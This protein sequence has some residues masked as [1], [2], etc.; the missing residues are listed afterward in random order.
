MNPA[1]PVTATAPRPDAGGRKGPLDQ[2]LG[3]FADVKGGELS[4][5][6]V[7]KK[8]VHG[9]VDRRIHEPEPGCCVGPQ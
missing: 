8:V 2:L 3:I 6:G 4:T 5:R 7:R 9:I 1:T